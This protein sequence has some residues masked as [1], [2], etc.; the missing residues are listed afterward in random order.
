MSRLAEF[1]RLEQQ[2][3]TQFAELEAI[4]GDTATQT[5]MAMRVSRAHF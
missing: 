1:R 3:A 4:K 5:E 2:S